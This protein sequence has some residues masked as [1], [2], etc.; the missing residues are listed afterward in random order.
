MKTKF[1]N[2]NNKIFILIIMM[3]LVLFSCEKENNIEKPSC[4]SNNGEC[5]Q[6][7]V[8]NEQAYEC[9]C[10]VGYILNEDGKTCD[11][12]DDCQN[13]LCPKN[14][15][16]VD[17]INSFTCNCD[18]AYVGHNCD[19]CAEGY[20]LFGDICLKSPDIV[21]WGTDDVDFPY[22]FVID[23]NNN[24]YVIGR[25]FGAF[26]GYL[27]SS[28][29]NT[30][31]TKFNSNMEILWTKQYNLTP[32]YISFI[33]IDSDDN[34]YI[35][36]SIGGKKGIV[37]VLLMKVDINGDILWEKTIGADNGN[38]DIVYEIALD[39]DNNIYMVGYENVFTYN[40][41]GSISSENLVL[42]TRKLD[43]E[44]NELWI[45]KEKV[46]ED[47]FMKSSYNIA[48]DNDNIY[49]ATNT[50]SSLEETESYGGNDIIII[51]YNSNGDR[52]WVK[53]YG[54][55]KHDSVNRI[56]LYY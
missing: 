45:K 2:N 56:I 11:N 52:V 10:D 41:S 6:Q 21:E 12:I 35:G 40:S 13:N 1:T 24:I 33:S 49:V 7:C 15:Q 16:C 20:E 3:I 51:K 17:G 4:G 42:A 38:D 29:G 34:L 47:Y 46:F 9:L 8:D 36:Y 26:D 14:S 19:E 28:E 37:D 50:T 43:S 27:S 54:S 25:T 31:L 48:V 44:G 5:S 30:F 53:Q 23:S 32:E 55:E 18:E 39:N 22:D